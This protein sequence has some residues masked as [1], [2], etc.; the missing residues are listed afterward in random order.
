[1]QFIIS[2]RV[3]SFISLFSLNFLFDKVLND[4][5]EFHVEA[6][7][8]IDRQQRDRQTETESRR[9]RVTEAE[10]QSV[11]ATE[12]ETQRNRETEQ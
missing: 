9:D 6:G 8:R 2:F 5:A 7:R 10:G 11:R 1:M 3:V 4:K 12:I